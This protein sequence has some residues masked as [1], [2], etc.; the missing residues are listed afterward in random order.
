MVLEDP[1]EDVAL[2]SIWQQRGAGAR[3]RMLRLG[4]F[5]KPTG[6]GR[7]GT[8][9][10]ASLDQA[11]HQ[12]IA[13]ASRF[14]AIQLAKPEDPDRRDFLLELDDVFA[15][16]LRWTLEWVGAGTKLTVIR[17]SGI[18]R[19]ASFARRAS[20]E[21]RQLERRVRL[22]PH[23]AS[24]K[25]AAIGAGTGLYTT[26]LGLRDRSW[27]L[28]AIISGLPRGVRTLDPQDDLGSLPRDDASMCL[29]A[30]MP[31]VKE[32]VVLR[33]LLSHRMESSAWRGANFGS[34]LLSALE[35]IQD[36]RQAGLDAAVDLLGIRGRVVLALDAAE[37]NGQ[38]GGGPLAA[39][40]D[41][42]MIVIAPGHLEVDLFPVLCCPGVAQAI[43]R[44]NALKVVVTKIMTAEGSDEA[45]TTSSHL[46]CL[47]TLTGATFDVVLATVG[48]FSPGQLRAYAA[49]GAYPVR[50]DVELTMPYT[51]RLLTEQ[52]AARGHLARHDPE[53]LGECLV[54]I[55]AEH[56][57]NSSEVEAQGA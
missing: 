44:S 46:S 12:C 57:L 9:L 21:D 23:I 2:D 25:I 35:E 53:R 4:T 28:T 55:G 22:L 17:T 45:P 27:S 52:L 16:R 15:T 3:R 43:R 32:N 6:Q 34:A 7:P 40:L 47:S 20:P 49:A 56:L 8:I 14:G 51:S 42:D 41:A 31:T 38:A 37:R 54:E 30:L 24:L 5:T 39:L 33:S 50:P 36:S 29:V 11:L 19:L 1:P 13:L 18:A 26:L 10:P 48:P